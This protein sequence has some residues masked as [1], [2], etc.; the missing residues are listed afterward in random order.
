MSPW[1]IRGNDFT[2]Y[3]WMAMHILQS[4]IKCV[5]C[6]VILFEKCFKIEADIK[7]PLFDVHKKYHYNNVIMGQ[8]A[9]QVTSLT[10]DYSTVHLG[11]DQRKHQN[12]A[13][14]AFVWGI[15]RRPVNSPHKGPV[16][17]KMFPFDDVIMTLTYNHLTHK[18]GSVGIRDR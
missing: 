3:S 13:S 8:K 7:W 16:T 17:R 6:K 18:E 12:S 15:H 5:P 4:K 10:I 14:L 2:I 9:S 1:T 11:T